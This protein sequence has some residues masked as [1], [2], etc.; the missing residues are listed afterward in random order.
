MNPMSNTSGRKKKTMLAATVSAV[1]LASIA[2]FAVSSSQAFA[3]QQT[4]DNEGNSTGT[5]SENHGHHGKPNPDAEPMLKQL[6]AQKIRE[7]RDIRWHG[8]VT[9]SYSLVQGIKVLGVVQKSNDTVSVTLAH[10]IPATKT[11]DATIDSSA[12]NQTITLVT[13]VSHSE[14]YPSSHL[15][16]STVVNA[17]WSGVTTI[18]L[19]LAGDHSLFDYHLMTTAVTH[20]TGQ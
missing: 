17:G 20:Q 2:A 4:T 3:E 12:V 16:G 1:L 5:T 15:D 6:I 19:K 11:S 10:V 7:D 14:K 9:D 13:V 8:L 18:D